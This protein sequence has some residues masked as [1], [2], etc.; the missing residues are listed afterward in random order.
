MNIVS[1]LFKNFDKTKTALISGNR[2]ISYNSLCNNVI[3]FS[4]YINSKRDVVVVHMTNSI[5]F[6]IA[7][8]AVLLAGKKVL[9]VNPMYPDTEVKK[10]LDLVQSDL[11]VTNIDSTLLRENSQILCPSIINVHYEY[12][13]IS[14]RA[15]EGAVIIPTSGTTGEAKLI[16]LTHINI[17]RNV[18]DIAEAYS[19]LSADDVEMIILP[20][21]AIFC[22]TTQMLV[23][24]CVGMTIDIW[25]GGFNIP[26]IIK[27]MKERN[28][29]YCQMVPAILRLFAF[30]YTKLGIELPNFKRTTVGGEPISIDELRKVS[31]V[32]API[33]IQQGY[34]M[35]ETSPVISS[36]LYR[37][38]LVY[39][40]AGKLMNSIELRIVPIETGNPEGV[41]YVKGPSVCEQTYDGIVLVDEEGW[42]NTGDIGYLDENEELFICGRMKDLII[43]GGMNVYPEE[44][45]GVIKEFPGVGDVLVYG[46]PNDIKG[47]IVKAKITVREAID[48]Q[49]LRHFC[50]DYLPVYKVPTTIDIVKELDKT[51]N[52]KIKRF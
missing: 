23:P 1:F 25:T 33:R 8:F 36:Q 24:L 15:E 31:G 47:E 50:A 18:L 16:M 26:V 5:E 39:G 35:T 20:M 2:S 49:K 6:V 34:G 14:D 38:T 27:E 10:Y 52:S 43:V 19:E 7:Y 12:P 3:H 46:E 4:K 13:V 45:E 40:S 11:L 44:I 9:L 30:F 28:V 48:V 17:C 21:T 42:L 41:I 22:H 51:Y 29:S 37:D 32:L